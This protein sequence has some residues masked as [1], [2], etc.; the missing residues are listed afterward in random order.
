VDSDTASS[1]QAPPCIPG[2]IARLRGRLTCSINEAA[3]LLGI[4]RSTA[5][6]AARD[7]SL[8]TVRLS[9]RLLVPTAKLLAML[10]AEPET[11]ERR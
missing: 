10:E 4:G 7:G 9:H 8:P 3:E 11:G 1:A 2:S 5:Y 6:A